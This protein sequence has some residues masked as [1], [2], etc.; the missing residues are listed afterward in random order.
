MKTL[1]VC[2][3]RDLPPIL[4]NN[5]IYFLYDKLEIFVG[6]NYF[7]DP[8][9]IV[10]SFP[11][12]FVNN[13]IYI[14]LDDGKI[15]AMINNELIEIALVESP[16]QLEILK[17]SGSTFFV[18]SN[19]RYL[20]IK[21]KTISLPFQNG[22]YELTINLASD[23]K[24]DENTVIGFNPETNQFEIIGN[25][26]DYNLVFGRKY[27]GV[28][29]NS[30]NTIVENN[31]ISS[32][33]KISPN[34]DNIIKNNKDGLYASVNDRVTS[35]V[36]QSWTEKFKKY[37]ENIDEYIVELNKLVEEAEEIISSGSLGA[38]ILA[39]LEEVYPEIDSALA[40]YDEYANKIDNLEEEVMDYSETR[41]NEFE[42]EVKETIKEITENPWGDFNS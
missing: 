30:I 34:Y 22:S 10:E 21:T 28:E 12:S 7:S 29:T 6:Q 38:K 14:C 17:Q 27:K 20:D 18:N 41:L 32:E 35:T 15:K 31:K 36:F 1:K 4:E 16:E 25:I 19:K 9:S 11:E 33:V 5:I 37:A 39:A 40:N 13:M 8:F 23:I 3:S 24:I 26:Q 2:L 42:E